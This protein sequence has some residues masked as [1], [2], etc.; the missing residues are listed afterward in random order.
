VTG[1]RIVATAAASDPFLTSR[2]RFPCADLGPGGSLRLTGLAPGAWRLEALG[3]GSGTRRWLIGGESVTA[4]T[5]GL[6][7]KLVAGASIAG[8][9]VDAHGA[10]VAG[11]RVDV[12]YDPSA[13]QGLHVLSDA[14]GR[15]RI[16]GLPPGRTYT[17]VA[18]GSRANE[19]AAGA[20]DLRLVIAADR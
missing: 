16:D 19:V 17:V 3:D 8:V 10:A 5:T 9:V 20:K 15:F 18:R 12:L 11:V 4:G 2:G 13:T 1:R 6:R 14:E 7:L